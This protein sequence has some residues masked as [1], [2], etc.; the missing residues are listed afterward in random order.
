[1]SRL[2]VKLLSKFE[3]SPN[4]FVELRHCT[5]LAILR[6]KQILFRVRMVARV[7]IAVGL[8]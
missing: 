8:E 7:R 1:M 5:N 6:G 4:I 2:P 3:Q